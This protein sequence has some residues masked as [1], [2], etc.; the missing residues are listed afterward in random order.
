MQLIYKENFLIILVDTGERCLSNEL[1]AF[2][3]VEQTHSFKVW[4]YYM[5]IWYILEIKV[6][7][8]KVI[9]IPSMF[10]KVMKKV[11]HVF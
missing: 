3:N 7:A 6:M 8:Y 4:F 10:E 5:I 11:Q 1:E 9:L 2:S